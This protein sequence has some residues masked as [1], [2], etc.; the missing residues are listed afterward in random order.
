MREIHELKHLLELHEMDISSLWSCEPGNGQGKA[1]GLVNQFLQV[2]W[3]MD[4]V[5][6]ADL[7]RLLYNDEAQKPSAKFRKLKE[8]VMDV[9]ADQVLMIDRKAGNLSTDQ[10]TY[11]AAHRDLIV[12]KILE[13]RGGKVAAKYFYNRAARRAKTY[14]LNFIGVCANQALRYYAGRFQRNERRFQHYHEQM[15]TC[16]LSMSAEREAT[17]YYSRVVMAYGTSPKSQLRVRNMAAAFVDV[18]EV[19][20]DVR[21]L[22]PSFAHPY[23]LLRLAAVGATAG[24]TKLLPVITEATSFFSQSAKKFA[25]PL[26]SFYLSEFVIRIL[27]QEYDVA[28]SVRQKCESLL[29]AGTTQW[30]K[31]Q[32]ITVQFY[33]YANQIDKA[34][35]HYQL[36]TKPL[37]DNTIE[38]S[39]QLRERWLVIRLYLYLLHACD[40]H[41]PV[42]SPDPLGVKFKASR[43]FNNIPNLDKEK[44]GRNIPILFAQLLFTLFTGELTCFEQQLANAEKY[45]TRH[46]NHA[47]HFRSKCFFRLLMRLPGSD[48]RSDRFQKKAAGWLK[49]LTD[50]PLNTMGQ[51][52]EIEIIPYETLFQFIIHYLERRVEHRHTTKVANKV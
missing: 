19:Q 42:P 18:L 1:S 28:E 8:R 32:E 23:Y 25:V 34:I 47:E 52:F 37:V 39:S 38:C 5:S 46:A 2:V 9:L 21:S 13:G 27:A 44:S 4:D 3:S 6:E 29:A 31:L 45:I 14:D 26:S 51:S 16:Q 48:Y 22:G 17:E 12:A 40:Q 11:Y 43:A 49:K 35:H 36:A 10:R 30:L 50:N 33:M 41:F 15:L 24:Y 20:Y 7:A